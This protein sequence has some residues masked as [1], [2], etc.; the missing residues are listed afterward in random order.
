MFLLNLVPPL[1]RWIA[2]GLMIVAVW[3]HGYLKGRVAGEEKVEAITAKLQSE[4]DQ[5]ALQTAKKIIQQKEITQNASDS[6]EENLRTIRAYYDKRLRQSKA[7]N[8]LPSLPEP[9]GKPDESTADCRS[10]PEYIELEGRAAETTGQLIDLQ[11]WV[12]GQ[13]K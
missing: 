1:Y 2:I 6:H 11:N 13:G 10:S 7:P 9:A 5:Q 3:G 12:T 4:R 8:G